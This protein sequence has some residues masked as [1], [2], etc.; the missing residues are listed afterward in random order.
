MP[1]VAEKG[2]PVY[3]CKECPFVEVGTTTSNWTCRK[4]GSVV[5]LN[6]IPASCPLG[7]REV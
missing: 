4:T 1:K 5:P 3:R 7:Q 2:N 6:R